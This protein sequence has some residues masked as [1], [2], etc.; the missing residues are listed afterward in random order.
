MDFTATGITLSSQI[1]DKCFSYLLAG[2]KWLTWAWQGQREKVLV[3]LN[4][5]CARVLDKLG[6]SLVEAPG[7][8]CCGAVRFHLNAQEDGLDDMRALIDAWWPYVDAID[9]GSAGSVE[10][11]RWCRVWRC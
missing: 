2:S 1:G 4:A 8:G 11:G 7:A 5:A 9:A 6:I 10:A 3:A